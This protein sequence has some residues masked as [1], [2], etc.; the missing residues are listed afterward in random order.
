M[1]VADAGIEKGNVRMTIAP[2]TATQH[3]GAL[4]MFAN[5]AVCSSPVMV[6][7]PLSST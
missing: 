2:P 3:Q 1:P 6:V 5:M 4:G 7:T